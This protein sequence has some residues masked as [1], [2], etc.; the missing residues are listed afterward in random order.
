MTAFDTTIYFKNSSGEVHP[1]RL[2]A[3]DA[4]LACRHHPVEWALTPDGFAPAPEG[5]AFS[6]G[7]GRGRA[8]VKVAPEPGDEP[9]SAASAPLQVD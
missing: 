1:V 4:L 2:P 9:G 5:F 3:T 7:D 8:S 6:A